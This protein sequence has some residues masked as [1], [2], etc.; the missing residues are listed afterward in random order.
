MSAVD[1]E[2]IVTLKD[3]RTRRFRSEQ[4]RQ[5]IVE[6]S[7]KPGIGSTLS[8]PIGF[9]LAM[10]ADNAVHPLPAYASF[11][12]LLPLYASGAPRGPDLPSSLL[13]LF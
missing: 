4:E 9:R 1:N 12:H 10:I 6:E 7:L 8:G 5:H 3:G 13:R 2:M 11:L